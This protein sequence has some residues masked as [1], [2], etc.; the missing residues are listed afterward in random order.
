MALVAVIIEI[1]EF[2]ED[3][4]IIVI[5]YVCCKIHVG[6]VDDPKPPK[7]IAPLVIHE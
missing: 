4:G 5:G 3:R 7:G 1:P 2:K 6:L